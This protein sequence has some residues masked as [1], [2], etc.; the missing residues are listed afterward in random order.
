MRHHIKNWWSFYTLVGLS[1]PLA[2]HCHEWNAARRGYETGIDGAHLLPLFVAIA[3]L[4]MKETT[5]TI[6]QLKGE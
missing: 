2:Q 4:V 3:W 5:Q 1:L 6:K